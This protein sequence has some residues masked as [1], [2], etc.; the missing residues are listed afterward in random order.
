[1]KTIVIIGQGQLG[2]ELTKRHLAADD[3]VISVSRT[4]HKNLSR[5]HQ[6]LEAD[7]DSLE[8]SLPIPESIHTLYYLAPPSTIDLSDHRM[9]AFLS[10]TNCLSISHIIYIST[11]GVYGDSQGNWVTENSAVA[12][13]AERAKR[14]LSAEQQLHDFQQAHDSSITILRCGAIYSSKTIN[15][16]RIQSNQKPVIK[17]EQ[18]PYTNRIHLDDLTEVC[19][20]AML[21]PADNVE[22]Y[23]VSDGQPST[24]TDFAWLL[25]DLTGIKRSDIIDIYEAN[26]YYSPA[27]MSYLLESKRLDISKLLNSLNPC[28]K[29]QN[30]EEGIKACLNQKED[31]L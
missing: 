31:L 3:S 6:H 24:T 15:L 30:I 1:M 25:S 18:A 26:N 27:Y 12:P 7:L 5:A 29:Y 13:A 19:W 22:I 23:N 16:T 14:R 9:T 8:K 4:A 21:N 11:S 2:H 28:F 10:S 17:P 20:Q